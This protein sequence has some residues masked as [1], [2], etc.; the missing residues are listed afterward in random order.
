M[1]NS[2]RLQVR[3][4]YTVGS[5]MTNNSSVTGSSTLTQRQHYFRQKQEQTV[6]ANNPLKQVK[7][8]EIC[9]VYTFA[10]YSN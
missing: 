8:V 4:V 6:S 10:I 1:K 9:R 7:Q 2:D 5:R 3:S